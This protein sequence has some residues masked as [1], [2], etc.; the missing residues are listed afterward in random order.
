MHF[1]QTLTQQFH[2][3]SQCTPT[4]LDA[5]IGSIGNLTLR[6]PKAV[7]ESPLQSALKL[8]RSTALRTSCFYWRRQSQWDRH[9]SSGAARSAPCVATGGDPR[10]TGARGERQKKP[11]AVV[12]EGIHN[13]SLMKVIL[14]RCS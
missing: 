14:T 3:K 7:P 10:V 9:L 6:V 2:L 8:F 11:K 12:T 5:A 1:T 13:S 4:A